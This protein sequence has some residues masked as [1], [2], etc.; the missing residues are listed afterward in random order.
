MSGRNIDYHWTL[1]A[2]GRDPDY[3]ELNKKF[4]ID[5]IRASFLINMVPPILKPCAF[6]NSPHKRIIIYFQVHQTLLECK[7]G[8]ETRDEAHRSLCE[9]TVGTRSAIWKG[10]GSEAGRYTKSFSDDGSDSFAYR[11]MFC[12]GS[13]RFRKGRNGL[14]KR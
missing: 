2:S 8:C 10:L 6:R 14:Y 3:L 5:I 12:P 11:M 7:K 9:G 1:D 4:T 13:S